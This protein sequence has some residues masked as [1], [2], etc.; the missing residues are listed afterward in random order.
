MHEINY[1][2]RQR[3]VLYVNI[4]IYIY[5]Y[6]YK[7][8]HGTRRCSWG[9]EAKTAGRGPTGRV[10]WKTRTVHFGCEV[11]SIECVGRPVGGSQED[12]HP[13]PHDAANEVES[14]DPT[15]DQGLVSRISHVQGPTRG[16]EW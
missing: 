13:G 3:C 8:V 14:V 11:E 10:D 9:R 1:K 12:F 4:C 15:T 16:V 7:R 5:I 2:Q 6:I